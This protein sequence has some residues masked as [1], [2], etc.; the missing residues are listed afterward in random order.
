M[1]LRLVVWLWAALAISAGALSLAGHSESLPPDLIMLH[2][3][4]CA[5][6]CWIGIEPGTT[7]RKVARQHILETFVIQDG[8]AV[9]EDSST[10]DLNLTTF[11]LKGP[12]A[13]YP[14]LELTL[15]AHNTAIVERIFMRY[16]GTFTAA[17][18][19]NAL[20]RPA[21]VFQ[22][23]SFPSLIFIGKYP[24]RGLRAYLQGGSVLSM[25]QRVV[26][27]ELYTD[28]ELVPYTDRWHGFVSLRRR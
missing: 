25:A 22:R 10:A 23:G 7:T 26:W 21:F 18:L 20:G 6:P 15:E 16:T 17:D 11:R 13:P 14:E 24:E 12:I 4:D 1:I 28:D 8:F 27:V 3:T 9:L 5:L 19:H 2:L